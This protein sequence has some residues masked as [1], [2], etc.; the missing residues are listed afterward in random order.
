MQYS[1][2]KLHQVIS[3][4]KILYKSTWV[5]WIFIILSLKKL[6]FTSRLVLLHVRCIC[7][8]CI[9]MMTQILNG[10][11]IFSQAYYL[12]KCMIWLTTYM[13]LLY[14]AVR[15]WHWREL[16]GFLYI[17]ETCVLNKWHHWNNLHSIHLHVHV[18][19]PVFNSLQI[20]Q[21][22]STTSIY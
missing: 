15:V 3:S 16:N 7:I 20:L 18:H 9:D 8:K 11:F 1:F 19:V 10:V 2:E 22:S 17:S 21:I 12:Y 5:K 13:Y 14:Y 4:I 6:I